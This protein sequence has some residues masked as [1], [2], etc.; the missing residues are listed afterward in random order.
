VSKIPVTVHT[1]ATLPLK[2]VQRDWLNYRKRGIGPEH[3]ADLIRIATDPAQFENEWD[4]EEMAAAS[5]AMRALAQMKAME[6]VGPLIQFIGRCYD[7]DCD[8]V[9]DELRGVLGR[10][11]PAALPELE[12]YLA[13][14]SEEA[15]PRG[16]VADA[17]AELAD[18]DPSQRDACIAILTRQLES[19]LEKE[20]DPDLNSILID[21]LLDLEAAQAAPVIQRAYESGQYDEE[22]TGDWEDAQIALGLKEPPEEDEYEEDE[23]DY[24]GGFP[25]PRWEDEPP[26]AWGERE[27]T[28]PA[29]GEPGSYQGKTPKER[30]EERA[31]ARR[32]QKKK[33]K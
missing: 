3:V 26:P 19:A 18:R 33:K 2:E 11:G 5:H 29:W 32:K 4:S 15:G 10:F 30:A 6:A 1:L 7:E 31:K 13:D 12:K 16:V 25:G 17:I 27:P 8:M 9:A 28:P 14:T 24:E 20:R 21:C 22:I 23:E